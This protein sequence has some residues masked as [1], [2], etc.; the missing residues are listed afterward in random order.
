[1]PIPGSRP[2]LDGTQA[3][4][5]A[6]SILAYIFPPRI[7]FA[8]SR[9]FA[10]GASPVAKLRRAPCRPP[11]SSS[12]PI[13][14]TRSHRT[15][16]ESNSR[17]HLSKPTWHNAPKE[18]E[19]TTLRRVS[20]FTPRTAPSTTG[21]GPSARSAKATEA[22]RRTT[23]AP[24]LQLPPCHMNADPPK[25]GDPIPQPKKRRYRPGTLALKEIRRYQANTDLLM[26]KLP[27]A[28]L[29]R[30]PSLHSPQRPLQSTPAQHR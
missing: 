19:A 2:G 26:S 17:G 5:P 10:P 25:A 3:I 1:M 15:A 22:K 12:T 28:R 8:L 21:T 23:Y 16:P 20:S 7:Q 4:C 11:N 14:R 13:R 18:S 27:F 29:V 30:P 24:D 9:S 6:A